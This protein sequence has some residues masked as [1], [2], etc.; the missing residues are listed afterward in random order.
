MKR[1]AR[2]NLYLTETEK[3]RLEQAAET[4]G[5]PLSIWIR[6]LALK[7]AAEVINRK[8]SKS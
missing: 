8:R 7:A 2:V 5:L 4:E 3:E 1:Q 6:V